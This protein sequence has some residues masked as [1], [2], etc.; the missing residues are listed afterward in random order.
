MA[1][2]A[3]SIA[4]LRAEASSGRLLT[5]Q[6]A[7]LSAVIKDFPGP[8]TAREVGKWVGLDARNASSVQNALHRLGVLE[9]APSRICAVT[10]KKVG[11]HQATPLAQPWL[12]G[13]IRLTMN[14]TPKERTA[15]ALMRARKVVEAAQVDAMAGLVTVPLADFIQMEVALGRT[16][17]PA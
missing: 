14:P 2:K 11:T 5:Q 4:A 13:A 9:W 12:D 7:F 15:R 6:E 10:G 1:R 17:V 16:E 8:A 3:G